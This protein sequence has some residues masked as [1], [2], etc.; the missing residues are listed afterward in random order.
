[1]EGSGKRG[2]L[3]VIYYIVTAD[4]RCLLLYVYPKSAQEDLGPDELRLLM[5]IVRFHF[6]SRGA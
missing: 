5:K 1:M 6:E 3:R 2:G 4:S